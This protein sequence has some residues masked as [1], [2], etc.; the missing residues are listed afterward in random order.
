MNEQLKEAVTTRN[1]SFEWSEQ[2]ASKVGEK[3]KIQNRNRKIILGTTVLCVLFVVVLLNTF[4]VF[5]IYLNDET[6][7]V[8][9]LEEWYYLNFI[10]SL[11]SDTMPKFL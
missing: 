11:F 6:H 2:I 10:A 5:D 9:D 7:F 1:N 4:G 3:K 8:M